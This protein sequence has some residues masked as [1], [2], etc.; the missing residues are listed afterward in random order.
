MNFY[1]VARWY[2]NNPG[3]VQVVCIAWIMR[4]LKFS[5]R[6]PWRISPQLAVAGR[7]SSGLGGITV[8]DGG[9]LSSGP[10]SCMCV[11]TRAQEGIII[12]SLIDQYYYP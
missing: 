6:V 12:Q 3:T 2:F 9:Q 8:R 4:S 10:Y 11:G 1:I 5:F 7:V